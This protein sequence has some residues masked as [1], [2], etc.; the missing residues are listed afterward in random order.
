M[1]KQKELPVV[2]IACKATASVAPNKEAQSSADRLDQHCGSMRAY[3]MPSRAN[4]VVTYKCVKC[5][6]VWSVSIGGSFHGV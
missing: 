1:S 6:H 5:K 2:N 4:G 3:Q